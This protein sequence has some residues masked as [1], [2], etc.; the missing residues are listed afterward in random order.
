MAADQ[1][2]DKTYVDDGIVGGSQED[3]DRMTGK[4]VYRELDGTI[5]LMLRAGGMETKYMIKSGEQNPDLAEQ[6]G[7]VVLGVPYQVDRDLINYKLKMEMPR[8][9]TVNAGSEVVTHVRI[10]AIRRGEEVQTRRKIL[11]MVMSEYDPLGLISPML[12]GSKILLRNLYGNKQKLRWDQGIGEQ[13]TL[14][15][16]TWMTALLFEGEAVFPRST[17]PPG[18]SKSPG[19]AGFADASLLA[20]CV[21]IYIV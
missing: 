18:A 3:V 20:I 11:S 13:D 12:V 10:A 19:L 4:M 9:S 6:L 14:S 15:W 7:G 16:T 17:R 5:P 2:R 21:S 8:E 1:L